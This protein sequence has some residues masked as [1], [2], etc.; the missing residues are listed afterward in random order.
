[1]NAQVIKFIGIQYFDVNQRSS[2]IQS[3]VLLAVRVK[4]GNQPVRTSENS[5]TSLVGSVNP[6]SV[7]KPV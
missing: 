3:G 4:R 5:L 2:N 1:M 7:V 6:G